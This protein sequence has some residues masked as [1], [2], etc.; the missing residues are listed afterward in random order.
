M[1]RWYLKLLGL[2]RRIPP[3][4]PETAAER[5]ERMHKSLKVNPSNGELLITQRYRN[6]C[7]DEIIEYLK[8][9]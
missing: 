9:M 2:F 5:R 7:I 4:I 1:A 8:E 3:P 6:A